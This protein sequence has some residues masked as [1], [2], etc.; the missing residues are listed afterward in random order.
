MNGV[1]QLSI[2]RVKEADGRPRVSHLFACIV[3]EI[4]MELR[5]KLNL[6]QTPSFA[7]TTLLIAKNHKIQ[8]I[9]ED[10]LKELS[11]EKIEELKR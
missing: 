7:L 4:R 9:K 8:A 3:D 5:N 6:L 10:I 2:K 1:N 11:I